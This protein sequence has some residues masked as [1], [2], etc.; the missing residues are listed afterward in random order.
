MQIKMMNKYSHHIILSKKQNCHS[1]VN[2]CNGKKY[3]L[4]KPH[5]INHIVSYSNSVLYK[6]V[7]LHRFLLVPSNNVSSDKL[8]DHVQIGCKL[9]SV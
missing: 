4:S 8:I 7:V 1:L 2:S 9:A 6:Y 5:F 3:T